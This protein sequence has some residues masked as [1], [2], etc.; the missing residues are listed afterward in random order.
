VAPR[1]SGE[2]CEASREGVEGAGV[3]AAV[4]V[5][6]PGCGKSTQLPQLLLERLVA[7]G[8]GG[9]AIS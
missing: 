8:R 3:G 1:C 9:E 7:Q 2:A 6:E 4:L 5:G